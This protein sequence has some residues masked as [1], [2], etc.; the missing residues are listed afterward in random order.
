MVKRSKLN[1]LL[2]AV[3][4]AAAPF[5]LTPRSAAAEESGDGGTCCEAESGACYL[6][7]DGTIIRESPA[8]H[9][10]SGSACEG[11]GGTVAN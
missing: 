5:A 6:N 11:G 3:T 8:Y 9:Q 10:E 2:L 7:L 4:M 1:V